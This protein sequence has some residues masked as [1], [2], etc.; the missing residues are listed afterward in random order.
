VHPYSLN[1]KA[2]QVGYH[3]QVILTGRRINDTKGA[4]PPRT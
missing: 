4:M 1:Q 3:P 2:A